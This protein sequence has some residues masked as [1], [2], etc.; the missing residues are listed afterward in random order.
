MSRFLLHNFGIMLVCRKTCCMKSKL[1][2]PKLCV[3]TGASSAG[4]TTYSSFLAKAFPIFQFDPSYT[5]RKLRD[6]EKDGIDYHATSPEIFRKMI[7]EDLFIEWEEVYKDKFY[8]TSKQTIQEILLK[9][10]IPL[11]VKDVK[12]AVAIKKYFKDDAYVI[13]IAPKNEESLIAKLKARGTE[14]E[15]ERQE[16]IDRFKFELTFKDKFDCCL[17]NDYTSQSLKEAKAH[18]KKIF[19]LA[20]IAA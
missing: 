5:T 10:R 7:K 19:S 4:K 17:K 15:K 11:L 12:G 14:T 18:V 3:I 16:R 9:N 6:A 13:Y 20:K 8:G 1:I 2:L